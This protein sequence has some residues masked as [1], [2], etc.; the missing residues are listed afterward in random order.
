MTIVGS[1]IIGT[2]TLG[3]RGLRLWLTFNEGS[4][5]TAYDYSFY[6]NHCTLN[7]PIWTN[8]KFGKCIYLDGIDDYGD[9][10]KSHSLDFTDAITI[11]VWFYSEDFST[12]R[13][14]ISRWEY[15]AS[16]GYG[17]TLFSDKYEVRLFNGV[18]RSNTLIY[19]EAPPVNTW[20]FIAATYQKDGDM[21]LYING[22]LKASQAG[23]GSIANP[24]LPLCIGKA[25]DGDWLW[26]KG[27]IDEVKLYARVLSDY[28]IQLLYYNRIG[29][30]P[31]KTI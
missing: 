15:W 30:V 12:E 17:I 3:L 22:E 21:K 6:N 28:E 1:K 9:C 13:P 24:D 7:G 25:A 11:A 20:T 27:M 23:T 16:K 18:D 8:G 19:Y 2:P 10:G 4:G 14:L 31:S 5:S 26:W 29:A